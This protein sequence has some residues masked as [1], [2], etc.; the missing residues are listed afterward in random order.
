[1]PKHDGTEPFE[2]PPLSPEPTEVDV[3]NVKRRELLDRL[4]EELEYEY[5]DL[6]P[7]QLRDLAELGL[8]DPDLTMVNIGRLSHKFRA[9]VLEVV[10]TQYV[11][12]HP[13]GRT[14]EEIGKAVGLRSDRVKAVLKRTTDFLPPVPVKVLRCLC[15]TADGF[16]GDPR[17]ETRRPNYGWLYPQEGSGHYNEYLGSCQAATRGDVASELALAQLLDGVPGHE[18]QPKVVA[19]ALALFEAMEKVNGQYDHRRAEASDA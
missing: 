1:M 17:C 19:M 6:E 5:G 15:R 18:L 12:E 7:D 11:R 9:M 13:E 3:A 2:R 4:A 10:V 8:F 14:A 16:C